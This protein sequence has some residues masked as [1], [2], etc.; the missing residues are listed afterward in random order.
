MNGQV[1]NDS[2]VYTNKAR[3]RDCFRCVR[4]CP[5]K[6]IRMRDGQAFV[7]A[8]E[9]LSCGTCIRECPQGAKSYRNDVDRV[10][11]LVRQPGLT[12]VSVAPS[13]AAVFSA[14]E[15]KRLPSALRRLGFGY[16]AETAVGAYHVALAT[17]EWAAGR[18]GET[19]VATACP[20][21][22]WTTPRLW[23]RRCAMALPAAG[24]A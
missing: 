19:H 20:A 12:A 2:V 3:C 4:V 17:A 9:C 22:V 15:Q 18:P 21:C 23:S 7:V 16:V 11:A 1:S 24:P 13:F 10:A 8:E 14:W 6:A 5:V